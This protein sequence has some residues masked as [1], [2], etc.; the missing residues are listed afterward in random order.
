MNTPA[1]EGRLSEEYRRIGTEELRELKKDIEDGGCLLLDVRE[2]HE[3]E[4]GHIPLAILMPISEMER[5][6]QELDPSMKIV[7]YCRSGK[8]SAR[9]ADLLAQKGFKDISIL[10]GGLNRWS[11]DHGPMERK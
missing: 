2:R 11:D 8:R 1:G 9:V 3:F 10:E 6:R 4:S 7:L 5:R